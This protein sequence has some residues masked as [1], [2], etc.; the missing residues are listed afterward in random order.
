MGNTQQWYLIIDDLIS[1]E[2]AKK[3]A[4]L[5]ETEDRWKL[6]EEWFFSQNEYYWV[7]REFGRPPVGDLSLP[8]KELL[9]QG[10]KLF[11]NQFNS[12]IGKHFTVVGHQMVPGQMVGIH[13]DSPDLDRG[14]IE[15]FR[16]VYYLDRDFSD[17]K[18]GHLIIFGSRNISDVLDA[19]RPIFN[20]AILMQLSDSSFHA[21]NKVKR[22]KRYSIVV[23]YWGY[24]ILFQS[25]ADQIKVR[26]LL[27]YIIDSGLE[28]ISHSKTTFAYHLYH[29]FK[30][31]YGW[32]QDIDICLA[33]LGHSLLGRIS[34]GVSYSKIVSKELHKIVG[35]RAF[36]IIQILSVQSGFCSNEN[37]LSWESK[38]AYIV[39][40]ANLIEQSTE[41]KDLMMVLTKSYSSKV[42]SDL[43]MLISKDVVYRRKLLSV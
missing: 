10:K 31:L 37:D 1:I 9:Y 25:F 15:N 3:L 18:G 36:T 4:C 42:S 21:I 8:I 40:L 13:N 27:K 19:L 32:G 7:R 11:E 6:H 5:A 16:L 38:A 29:T 14:R 34:S 39:E 41:E 26:N 23:S 17:N 28:E 35:D 30:I 20:S 2:S 12:V 33:G 22:G 24:P 43:Q